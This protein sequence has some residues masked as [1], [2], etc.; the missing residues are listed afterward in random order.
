M[1]DVKVR[2]VSVLIFNVKPEDFPGMSRE[3][4][5]LVKR[6]GP[7]MR[8]LVECIVLGNHEKTEMLLVSQWTGRESWTSAQWDDDLGRSLTGFIESATAFQV[9]SYEP[10]A[11]VRI[12]PDG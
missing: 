6:K 9:H 5:N 11:I 7:A 8:G 12:P 1:L 3:A 10:I 4:A 2:F